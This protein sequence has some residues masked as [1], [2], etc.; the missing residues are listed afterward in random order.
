[1]GYLLSQ[2]ELTKIRAALSDPFNDS[3]VDYD[4][5][6]EQ[7]RGVDHQT[8]YEVL[9]S[10]VAPVCFTN[11]ESAVPSVWTGFDPDSLNAMIEE[12]LAARRNDGFHRQF[13]KLFVRWLSYHY[14]YMWKEIVSR[15]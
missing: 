11:I 5:I 14:G 3:S 6:A 4:Y 12:R 2:P 13:D 9:Y 7:V 10:E 1:L 8:L 15:L